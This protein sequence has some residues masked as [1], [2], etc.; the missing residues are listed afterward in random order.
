MLPLRADTRGLIGAMMS[1]AATPLSPCYVAI[2]FF[3]AI[4]SRHSCHYYADIISLRY[5]TP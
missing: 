4:T 5:D 2:D 3:D 1:R